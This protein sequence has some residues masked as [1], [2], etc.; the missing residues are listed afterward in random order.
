MLSSHG[1]CGRERV[2]AALWRARR[3]HREPPA[4]QRVPGGRIAPRRAR[5][6][7]RPHRPPS[8]R[9]LPPPS[10]A[11]GRSSFRR[12][13]PA[14]GAPPS[15]RSAASTHGVAA[16]DGSPA[17]RAHSR[18]CAPAAVATRA[19]SHAPAAAARGCFAPA[20]ASRSRRAAAAAFARGR[21]D[22][23]SLRPP[24]G[25]RRPLVWPRL[26]RAAHADGKPRR[27]GA[28]HRRKVWRRGRARP[29]ARRGRQDAVAPPDARGVDQGAR[30]LGGCGQHEPHHERHPAVQVN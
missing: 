16:A 2:V 10:P 21:Y 27:V 28:T 26:P 18:A 30:P 1:G 3:M 4:A 17:T 23:G 19:R 6:R 9:D 8:R 5:R 13:A 25:H 20:A 15:K 24:L 22:G 29:R 11:R 7:A 14:A 12:R